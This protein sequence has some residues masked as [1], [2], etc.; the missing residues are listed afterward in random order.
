M[1]RVA[2]NSH[3]P[4][5]DGRS[6]S[7]TTTT[8]L[9]LGLVGCGGISAA[10]GKAALS[11]GVAGQ[12]AFVACC[13]PSQEAARR[14][15]GQYSPSAHLHHDLDEMLRSE[16]LDAVVLATW[17]NQH[18]QQILQCLSGGV[19]SILCEKALVTTGEDG[20]AVWRAACA[21]DALV[22]EG[23]MYRHHPAIRRIT[24]LIASGAIGQLDSV[25]AEFGWYMMADPSPG[26]A[27]R[28]WRLRPECAGGVPF[29]ALCYAVDACGHLARSLPRRVMAMGAIDPRYGVMLREHGMIE[30]AN[31]TIG[32]VAASHAQQFTQELQIQ[33]SAGHLFLPLAWTISG[34]IQL[35]RRSSQ[36]WACPETT[37]EEIPAADSHT[38]QLEN[39][40]AAISGT[41]PPLVPLV[42]SV[43]HA[44]VSQALVQSAL[45]RRAVELAL[46]LALQ[47]AHQA[48]QGAAV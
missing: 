7:S 38:L 20:L 28:N 10:H 46:P 25:R 41:E 24:A 2:P 47:E 40:L 34:G 23:F 22:M 3:H 4:A 18:R 32:M 16:A 19:R 37:L 11:E 26:D 29:D 17:P 43:V 1:P 5:N 36:G 48:L 21:A 33:G 39:F 8:R 12:A 15:A 13:D 30:Y 6:A 27:P 14:W 45:T 44:H 35:H 9:R 42:E 31:G